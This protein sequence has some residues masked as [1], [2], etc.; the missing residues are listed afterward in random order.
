MRTLKLLCGTS[1]LVVLIGLVTPAASQPANSAPPLPAHY[2]VNQAIDGWDRRGPLCVP[3]VQKAG[4]PPGSFEVLA[5]MK[6][7][8]EQQSRARLHAIYDEMRRRNFVD[9]SDQLTPAGEAWLNSLAQQGVVVP[10]V[11][12]QP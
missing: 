5:R 9:E 1:A 11:D 8:L 4:A 3:P 10:P 12:G 2:C 6:A 7:A